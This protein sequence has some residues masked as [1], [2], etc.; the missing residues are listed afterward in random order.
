MVYMTMPSHTQR[1][2]MSGWTSITGNPGIEFEYLGFWVSMYQESVPLYHESIP[3]YQESVPLYHESVSLYQESVPLYQESVDYGIAH[4]VCLS[5]H[6]S[7]CV[8]L[9]T[10]CE[11]GSLCA[12][13]P[14]H[15]IVVTCHTRPPR[16]SRVC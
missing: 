9:F 14:A 11:Q 7:T 1:R 3:M 6:V 12:N 15:N 10:T 13:Y 16:R 2:I 8:T 5:R 4:S